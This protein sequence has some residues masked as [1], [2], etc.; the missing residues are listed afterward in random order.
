ML[1]LDHCENVASGEEQVLLAVVLHLGAAVLA[2]DDD[3]T[4][5]DINGNTKNVVLVHAARANGQNLALLGL[6]LGGVRDDQARS[7]GLLGF[8]G[9]NQDA[10]FEWLDGDRHVCRPFE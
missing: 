4:D 5:L 1:L 8:E 3:V 2:V 10:V 6:L 9:L 7:S